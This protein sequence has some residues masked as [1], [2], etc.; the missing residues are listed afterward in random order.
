ML[1]KKKL[2]YNNEIKLR[3]KHKPL[4]CYNCDCDIFRKECHNIIVYIFISAYMIMDTTTITTT[5]KPHL[6]STKRESLCN[7][8]KRSLYYVVKKI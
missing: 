8:F 3:F 1:Y 2:I 6:Y 7:F 5:P 4:D